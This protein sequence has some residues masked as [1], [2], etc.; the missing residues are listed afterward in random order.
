LLKGIQTNPDS[1]YISNSFYLKS[2]TQ[3]FYDHYV[4]P[5]GKII[6]SMQEGQWK[7][8]FL[9]TYQAIQK[10]YQADAGN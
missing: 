1:P 9:G 10:K 5:V 6:S 3:Y 8:K 2:K 4:I 7:Q